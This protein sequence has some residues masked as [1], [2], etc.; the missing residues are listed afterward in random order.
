MI[1]FIDGAVVLFNKQWNIKVITFGTDFVF[2]RIPSLIL[3]DREINYT[4]E[5]QH[6]EFV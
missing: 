2:I 4:A 5:A 6:D 3:Q 1:I